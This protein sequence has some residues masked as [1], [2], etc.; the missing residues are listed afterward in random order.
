MFLSQSGSM[1]DTI[2]SIEKSIDF[3]GSMNLSLRRTALAIQAL[4][5]FPLLLPV[6]GLAQRRQQ[7]PAPTGPWMNASLS[8]DQRAD[9][10][11]KEL[12]LDEKVALLHGVGMPTDEAVTPENAASNRGVGYVVGVPR[13]GIPGIDMSDAAY[14][15]RSSGA[16]GRYSTALP[17][18]VAAAASWD[19]EAA[20][21]YGALIGRELRAQGYNMS[22]GGGADITREPRNGRTFEYLGE[23][24][25]LAG[26]L[27][28]KLIQGTQSEHV[29]GDLKHYAFNDQESGRNSVNAIIGDRAARE[30]DL[31]AFEIGVE[32]GHPAAVM[33]S[34]N[35]LN[36]DF[37]CENNYL[38]NQV[39]KK[40]WNFPGFVL[41]DWGGTHSTEKASAA[42]LDN[43]EPDHVFYGDLY[44]AAV[45]AGKIPVAELDEHV[46]RILH[47]MFA[48]GVID[49]PR[50]RGVI[51]PFAGLEVAR[52]IEEGSIVLLKNEHGALPL[53]ADKIQSIV[54][55]GAHSDVG[56]ISGGGSAQVDPP[57]GNAISPPGQGAT[58]W[59]EQIWFPTSPLK[60]IQARAPKA[61]VRYDPGTD[62]VAAAAAAKGADVVVL[63]AYQWE[64]EGM[65][66]PTLSLPVHQDQLIEKVTA[67]NPHTIVVLE[68]GSP[69]TMPWV[70]APAAIL[71]A[72]YGGSDGANALGNVLF[73]SVNPSGKLP[74]TFPL[75]DADLPHPT[76]VQPPPES[77]H[78]SAAVSPVERGKGMPPFDRDY[79]EGVKVGYKWYDAE[80]KAVLFPFG[81]GLSYTSYAYSGLAVTPGAT[82][83]AT[84][85]VA[86]TGARG[87][88]EIAEVYASLPA[89]A[90]EPPKR[91]VG[92]SKVKIDAGGQQTVTVDIDPKYLSIF[93][94]GTQA[95]KLLPGD[96]TILV[97]GSSQD[98]PLKA[99]VTLK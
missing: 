64:S 74:N 6:S 36:G 55:I 29:I 42:G 84:F 81:F 2:V 54:V 38:L 41:S 44:K 79:S 27:V 62:P 33:C 4:A 90:Q 14:G 98:L 85:T 77:R 69:V 61:T 52:K 49:H 35:R 92:W 99:T 91:L 82:I 58:H 51:D 13:L 67:A 1:V 53:D 34:Y 18:N 26:T 30:S 65:D 80:K 57:G 47:A 40:D 94:E 63:F 89:S 87:G 37:A 72:W 96:Y 93:D 86:N 19:P 22:L 83:K 15:V 76:I 11:L 75:N 71:E 3:G 16:N 48:A 24:P 56:M 60:A 31:L 17:A 8:P 95:W 59:Q 21:A 78:F 9:L 45:E 73:G 70:S 66:L 25:V 12:T 46:H 43:E 20:F 97:G 39:L 7:A 50:Q 68:T 88:G 5:L 32:Q 28:A 23:D 10:V